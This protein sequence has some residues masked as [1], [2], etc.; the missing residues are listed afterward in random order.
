M[1]PAFPTASRSSRNGVDITYAE[2]ERRSGWIAYELER[3]GIGNGKLVGVCLERTPDLL[4]ALLGVMRA[5]AGYVPLDSAYPRARL[6]MVADDARLSA[7][8]LDRESRDLLGLDDDGRGRRVQP[9]G[10]GLTKVRQLLCEHLVG[11]GEPAT[12]PADTEGANA[13]CAYVIFTS[14]STGRPKGVEVTHGNVVNLLH[15]LACA[16]GLAAGEAALGLTTISFDIHVLELW[17]PLA[18]GGKVLLLSSAAARDPDV[19]VDVF[20]RCRPALVQATPAQW[21]MLIDSNFQGRQDLRIVAGG[22][23]LSRQLADALLPRC[24]ELW[25]AYGPTETTVWSSVG[26]VGADGPVLL[27]GLVDNTTFHVVAPELADPPHDSSVPELVTPGDV[28][29]L[30]IGGAGVTRGY[31]GRPDLTSERFLIRRFGPDGHMERVYRTGDLVRRHSTGGLEFLGRADHQVKIRGHRIE[32]GEIDAALSSHWAVQ[33]VVVTATPDGHGQQK[34]VAYVQTHP[35][36]DTVALTVGEL[37]AY[38]GERIPA[39]MVPAQ[40][41]WLQRMPLTPNG[42]VDRAALST[43][44]TRRTSPGDAHAQPSGPQER[45]ICQVFADVLIDTSVG[46][47]DSFFDLG[48]SSVI[49]PKTLQRLRAVLGVPL[50]MSAF[51]QSPTARGLAATLDQIGDDADTVV[52]RAEQDAVVTPADRGVARYTASTHTRRDRHGQ[53]LFMTGATGFVGAHVLVRLLDEP[54]GTERVILLVRAATEREGWERIDRALSRYGLM[55][56][57]SGWRRRVSVVVGNV[58]ARLLG[59]T[60]E[61]FDRIGNEADVVLHAASAVNLLYPYEVMRQTNVVGTREVIR[62]ATTGGKLK[63][64]HYTSTLDVFL[65]PDLHPA[66]PA[67]LVEQPV[68]SPAGLPRG[69]EVSKWAAE[70]LLTNAAHLFNLRVSVLRIGMVVG[71]SVTGVGHE[72]DEWHRFLCDAAELGS[73][74]AMDLSWRAVPVDWLADAVGRL[75]RDHR[76]QPARP[77]IFHLNPISGLGMDEVARTLG[78]FLGAPVNLVKPKDWFDQIRNNQDSALY[79]LLD[80]FDEGDPDTGRNYLQISSLGGV[81]Y[82]TSQLRAALRSVGMAPVAYNASMLRRSLEFLERKGRIGAFTN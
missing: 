45:A 40:F 70:T 48:G 13:G 69:Y 50:S 30:W 67:Q 26:R 20:E 34:L 78:A 66:Q 16:P 65:N 55:P 74:P 77:D 11:Q 52:A 71:D 22:E 35:G 51:L 18:V 32:L 3:R 24:G 72:T 58:A 2:L 12:V 76:A 28:G 42:K 61:T 82:D 33:H 31:V 47:T 25:N 8:L 57:D 7:L 46:A 75:V 44:P 17:L 62:L 23:A 60:R 27:T 41:V 6:D 15:S 19:I 39:F 29:E 1:R 54:Q 53:T 4:A 73:L 10:A 36:A 59:L 37:Q 5:G 43:A 21:R 49:V 14:G 64:V 9:A 38:L 81:S 56:L 79:P 63:P 80:L 68:L